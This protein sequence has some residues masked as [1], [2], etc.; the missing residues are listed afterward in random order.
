MIWAASG[1]YG[2]R[3]SIQFLTLLIAY[4]AD[5]NLRDEQGFTALMEAARTGNPEVVKFLLEHQADAT[6]TDCE[7]KTAIQIAQS[8]NQTE[9]VRILESAK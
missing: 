5:V 6:L 2:P 1:W 9:V 4:K 3:Q 8:F 7:G